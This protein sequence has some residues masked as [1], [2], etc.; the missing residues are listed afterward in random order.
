MIKSI[1][2][3]IFII[4]ILGLMPNEVQ[5]DMCGE[6]LRQADCGAQG[7]RSCGALCGYLERGTVH[8]VRG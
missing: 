5:G 2:C 1:F 7:A 3:A 6:V 8:C 4:L